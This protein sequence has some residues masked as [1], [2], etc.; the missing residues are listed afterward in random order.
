MAKPSITSAQNKA[1]TDAFLDLTGDSKSLYKP[2]KFEALASSLEYVAAVYTEKLAKQLVTKDADS[3]GVLAKS[4]VAGDVQ[5]MGTIYHVEISAEKYA[6][7]IDEGVDGWENSRGS[8]FHFKTKGVNPQG[9]MVKS[10]KAWLL[11][12]GEMSRVKNRPVSTKESKRQN[13]TDASTKAAI[14]TAYMIKRFGIKPTHFWRDAT[15]EMDEVIRR[16]FSAALQIDIV[17]NLTK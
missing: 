16:E 10:V 1:G 3:S 12:E 2:V 11:R 6:S 13:I 9:E 15:T 8:Q 7:F 14:S 4:I 5:L 17:Q